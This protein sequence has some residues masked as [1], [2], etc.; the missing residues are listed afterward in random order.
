MDREERRDGDRGAGGEE[1]G[2]DAAVV[3]QQAQRV[4]HAVADPEPV[5]AVGGDELDLLDE[6]VLDVAAGVGQGDQQEAHHDEADEGGQVPALGDL[7]A[8]RLDRGG[9]EDLAD[10]EVDGEREPERGEDGGEGDVDPEV[11]G[12]GGIEV[13]GVLDRELG[14]GVQE[15]APRHGDEREDPRAGEEGDEAHRTVERG[16]EAAA[17]ERG[18]LAEEQRVE[19]RG[20]EQEQDEEQELVDADRREVER[21]GEA[22]EDGEGGDEGREAD[23]G[24]EDGVGAAGGA[25]R[26]GGAPQAPRGERDEPERG[27]D[28]GELRADVDEVG[29]DLPDELRGEHRL[30]DDR[31][32]L[33]AGDR[34]LEALPG[35]GVA[36]VHGRAGVARDRH[37]GVEEQARGAGE[38]GLRDDAPALEQQRGEGEEAEA[39]RDVAGEVAAEGVGEAEQAAPAH[40][41]RE[42]DEGRRASARVPEAAGGE[43]REDPDRRD[44]EE[45]GDGREEPVEDGVGVPGR[46]LPDDV[47]LEVRR[48]P[49]GVRL[50]AR[51]GE[52]EDEQQEGRAG[53]D[54]PGGHARGGRPGGLAAAGA[55][56]REAAEDGE[57]GEGGR[58]EEDER[59]VRQVRRGDVLR[60]G[61]RD[62]PERGAVAADDARPGLG[63]EVHGADDGAE[64]V[65]RGVL[66]EARHGGE[67]AELEQPRAEQQ[68]EAGQD[69][70]AEEADVLEQ[71]HEDERREREQ[72]HLVV[73]EAEAEDERRQDEQPVGGPPHP[74]VGE[75]E[76][77]HHEELAEGVDLDDRAL[78]PHH[79][80]EREDEGGGDAR[81]E[82]DRP[83]ARIVR[84]ARFDPRGRGGRD[85]DARVGVEEPAAA[86]QVGGG[87]GDEHR[88]EAAGECAPEGGHDGDGPGGVGLAA[89]GHPGEQAGEHPGA[90]RPGRVP[91]RVGDA[92]EVAR[93]GELAAVLERDGGGAGEEVDEERERG[94]RPEGGSVEAGEEGAFVGHGGIHVRWRKPILAEFR[95]RFHP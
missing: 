60:Q 23:G 20:R 26:R 47:R 15:A 90:H 84:E 19:A 59:E 46:E 14:H 13:E 16:V 93:G 54:D 68:R 62:G 57:R 80:R 51:Q 9:A 30:G 72:Q 12:G 61:R 1:G 32:V 83:V 37:V 64:V 3:A 10:E 45:E 11:E 50:G 70:V 65:E 48:V 55:E 2:A 88:R 92:G 56:H 25:V 76:H 24:R 69:E 94:A 33:A 41:D 81:E 27:E 22:V 52:D 77:E 67:R 42:R 82:R 38:D 91:G 34:V 18:E 35:A 86:E 87:A 36:P 71:D 7:V 63:E 85:R 75:Q 78:R 66:R 29:R 43:E 53:G 8:V 49:V 58:D 89:E 6:G 39:E 4:G 74:A 31:L 95:G 44:A 28:E 79:R 17:D 5:E 21:A 40:Q 73:R